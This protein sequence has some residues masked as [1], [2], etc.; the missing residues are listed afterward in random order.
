M[1]DGSS[2]PVRASVLASKSHTS[3]SKKQPLD[4][5][6]VA[7][8][9]PESLKPVPIAQRPPHLLRLSSCKVGELR[10][11]GTDADLVGEYTQW[12]LDYSN[13]IAEN[14]SRLR[15]ALWCHRVLA[16]HPEH[17]AASEL[18]KSITLLLGEEWGVYDVPFDRERCDQI[19]RETAYSMAKVEL[20]RP[21]E[22]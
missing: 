10:N 19:A 6:I 2:G 15:G 4:L 9:R 17:E 12:Q 3:L 7:A 14:G 8:R 13:S 11:S 20:R 22:R 16:S 21:E 18:L 1:P 5:A